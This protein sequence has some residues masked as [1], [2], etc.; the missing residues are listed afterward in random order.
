[1]R[2]A[3]IST[4]KHGLPSFVYREIKAISRDG[5]E[6]GVFATKYAAGAYAPDPEWYLHRMRPACIICMQPLYLLKWR[7]QYVQL[8]NIAGINFGERR[9]MIAIRIT[10]NSCPTRIIC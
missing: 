6:I 4:M 9:I 3:Y 8:L 7:R 1:M 10:V 2:I 5:L